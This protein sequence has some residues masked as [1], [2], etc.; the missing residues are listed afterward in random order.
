MYSDVYQG[1]MLGS[2]VDTPS[3]QVCSRVPNGEIVCGFESMKTSIETE[4]EL[5][6]LPDKP[7]ALKDFSHTHTHTQYHSPLHILPYMNFKV[8]FGDYLEMIMM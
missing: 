1:H 6:K 3:T 8:M 2:K 7:I 5:I 4:H